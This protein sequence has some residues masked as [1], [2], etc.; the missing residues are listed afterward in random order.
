MEETKKEGV[1][2]KIN[3]LQ[4]RT[5]YL[6]K[7]IVRAKMEVFMAERNG[8]MPKELAIK[9]QDILS[10]KEPGKRDRGVENRAREVLRAVHDNP[11]YQKELIH[12]M[13]KTTQKNLRPIVDD[14]PSSMILW[15]LVNGMKSRDIIKAV[16]PSGG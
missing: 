2:S 15:L 10:G 9:L 1:R 11:D 13:G 7:V 6:D 14:G 16:K 4:S 8:K 3:R 5:T 12:L